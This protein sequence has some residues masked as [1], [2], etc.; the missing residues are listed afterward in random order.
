MVRAALISL[1][2]TGINEAAAHSGLEVSAFMLLQSSSIFFAS[3]G[4]VEKSPDVTLSLRP[5]TILDSLLRFALYGLCRVKQHKAACAK[6][7]EKHRDYNGNNG[8]GVTLFALA[9]AMAMTDQTVRR[10]NSA[11]RRHRSSSQNL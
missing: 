7:N 8:A 2:Y 4:S 9:L 5:P 3:S 6:R 10:S 1:P 11:K